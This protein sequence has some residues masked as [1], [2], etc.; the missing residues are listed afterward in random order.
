MA[1]SVVLMVWAGIPPGWIMASV[2]LQM[3]VMAGLITGKVAM[4]I[5][6]VMALV[7]GNFQ[8]MIANAA[9]NTLALA[10]MLVNVVSSIYGMV[11]EAQIA[12]YAKD[13][14]AAIAAAEEAREEYKEVADTLGNPINLFGATLDYDSYWYIASGEVQYAYDSLYDYDTAIFNTDSK[15]SI[16]M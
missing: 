12:G 15:T 16:G 3:A 8:T 2:G 14:N 7:S 9:E 11:V 10:S 6:I 13:A 4:V 5:G 1:I